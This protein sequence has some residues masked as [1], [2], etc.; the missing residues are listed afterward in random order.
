MRTLAAALVVA[1]APVLALIVLAATG[2][3]AIGAAFLAWAGW[4][5]RRG[6][7]SRAIAP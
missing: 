5:L 2:W 1:G 6:A 4:R 7:A 3:V